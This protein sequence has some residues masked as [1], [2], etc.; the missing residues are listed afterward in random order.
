MFFSVGRKT[1]F[2]MVG[3][4]MQ[5]PAPLGT[6]VVLSYAKYGEDTKLDLKISSWQQRVSD[7]DCVRAA[8]GI[9]LLNKP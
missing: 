9:Q 8:W 6:T 1:P 4:E 2:L 5:A 7:S 3:T